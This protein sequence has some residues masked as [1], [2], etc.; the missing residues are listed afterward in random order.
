MEEAELD[1]AAAG[2]DDATAELQTEVSEGIGI[3]VKFEFQ[4]NVYNNIKNQS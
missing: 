1:E 3:K 4:L 2:P